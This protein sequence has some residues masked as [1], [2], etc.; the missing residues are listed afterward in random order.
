MLLNTYICIAVVI[1]EQFRWNMI[2][3]RRK[4]F[5]FIPFLITSPLYSS[6]ISINQRFHYVIEKLINFFLLQVLM[7]KAKNFCCFFSLDMPL[8]MSFFPFHLTLPSTSFIWMCVSIE[9]QRYYWTLIEHMSCEW[10]DIK[11]M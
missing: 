10:G 6:Q 11:W 4:L 2:F 5:V 8:I 9:C 3:Q 1:E 7:K